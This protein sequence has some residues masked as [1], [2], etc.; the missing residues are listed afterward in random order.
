[1]KELT[2][3]ATIENIAAATAFVDEQLEALDCPMRAQMQIDVAIDELFGN[4]AHYAYVPGTGEATVRVG[5]D[6]SS[7]LVS[8]TFI[9]SGVPYN[10][11]EKAD[12]DVTLSA[13][14][15]AVGGLGIFMVK[16]IMD[17]MAYERIDGRNVLT[18]QKRI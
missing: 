5:F 7:R 3:A 8:L 11:L 16:K 2:L 13:E 18:V 1:M 9:D 15:R 4:I 10:P 12:P 6:E 17:G 14:E